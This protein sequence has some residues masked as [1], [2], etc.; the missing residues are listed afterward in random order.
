MSSESISENYVVKDMGLAEWGRREIRMAEAEM[1]GL[2]AIREEYRGTKPLAG[3]RITG[4]LHMTIQTAVLIETLAEL[5]ADL[6][7]ASCNIYSTQDHAAAAIAATGVPVFAYKGETLEEYWEYTFK[8]LAYEEGPQLIVDDGGDA[9]LLI[10]RGVER[11]RAYARTGKVPEISH[12]NKELSIVDALLNRQLLVD[13]EYWQRMATGLL[14]VSEETTTGVHRL[15]HMARNGELLFPAFNV[16]DSVTK[17]KFDN[18]YGCRESLID[19]IKRATD[20][21]IAGKKCVVL[22]YGDVGKGCAQAFKGMGALVSVTEVDPICALQAAMEGFAVVDMDEACQ[23]GD[24]FVTTTGNVDV[25]TRSHMD[26][27]KNEA[28]VCNIGHFD[29]EI[30]VDAL[31]DDPS[32][33]VHEV[34]PQVDQIE[35]PDGKRITVLAKGRLVNLGCA[36]GHPSFVMSNSFTNQVLAQIELWQNSDRYENKVY[37]LPKQLDEKVARLHL[38]NLGVKLTRMTEKQADYLGVPVDGP[39]KPEH[40]RY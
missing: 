2:M 32:L 37:V 28:I 29:S 35:W 10:H 4:S 18:L 19:G 14:G 21:M 39:Y 16:N 33:T 9:T 38:A 31:Y 30:Q 20:V 36:T 26:V 23:W 13:A 25:I 6:R 11:E 3:A 34:K 17:S 40:Y 5:G 7:W 27:M 12:D 8:A 24:I 22:G 1:P 15:Y